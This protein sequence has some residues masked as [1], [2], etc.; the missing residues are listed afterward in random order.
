MLQARDQHC[1]APAGTRRTLLRRSAACSCFP[2]L[3][4][5][6]RTGFGSIAH[7]QADRE[8]PP[9]SAAWCPCWQ[10]QCCMLPAS[11]GHAAR[12]LT[13]RG[14]DW[15]NAVISTRRV[16]HAAA[17]RLHLV[18]FQV[19]FFCALA[20]VICRT[21]QHMRMSAQLW[22]ALRCHLRTTTIQRRQLC[23]AT[24]L[25]STCRREPA[26]TTCSQ[27]A[28]YFLRHMGLALPWSTCR[29]T[30]GRTHR[31]RSRTHPSCR[32]QTGMTIHHPKCTKLPHTPTRGSGSSGS[33]P[34]LLVV[35]PCGPACHPC[36]SGSAEGQCWS[37]A[38]PAAKREKA[39]STQNC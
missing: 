17:C 20:A 2:A 25:Q 30:T 24:Q 38:E 16:T 4:S 13:G 9:C 33:K 29:T 23:M 19:G 37:R 21:A 10:S 15:Q 32:T 28:Y 12:H 8:A 27:D 39:L 35:W 31:R 22:S 1:C 26:L 6:L 14:F 11:A 18:H 36:K 7:L 34:L 5:Q 3:T